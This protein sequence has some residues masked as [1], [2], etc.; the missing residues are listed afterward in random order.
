MP[1]G[2]LTEVGILPPFTLPDEGILPDR[3][4]PEF[5]EGENDSG[6]IDRDAT[7]REDGSEVFSVVPEESVPVSIILPKVAPFTAVPPDSGLF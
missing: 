4:L 7:G 2:V 6:L 3:G 5:P 1:A